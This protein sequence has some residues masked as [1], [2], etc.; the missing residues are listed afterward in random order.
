M[1]YLKPPM[2]AKFG[3]SRHT[4]Y[5][6]H[7]KSRPFVC[8]WFEVNRINH[9]GDMAQ[10]VIFQLCWPPS[11]RIWNFSTQIVYMIHKFVESLCLS[12][13]WGKS[14]KPFMRYGTKLNFSTLKC[15]LVAEFGTSWLKLYIW[16]I[17][18]LNLFV[19]LWFEVN[20]INHSWDMAQNMIFRL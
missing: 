5:M 12:L 3:T 11:G 4:L 6:I 17:S 8:L 16:F 9:S 15:P 13:I 7:Q 14:N 1:I 20:R 10:N 2:V 19:C 18:L